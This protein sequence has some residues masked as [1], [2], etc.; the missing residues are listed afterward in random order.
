MR[1]WGFNCL[2]YLD[3]YYVCADDMASCQVAYEN[4]WNLLSDVG[5]VINSKKS[6]AHQ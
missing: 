5:F 4:F 6:V 2:V 1:R 3:D